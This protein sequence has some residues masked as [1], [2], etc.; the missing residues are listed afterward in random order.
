[1]FTSKHYINNI[2]LIAFA[3]INSLL[4]LIVSNELRFIAFLLLLGYLVVFPGLSLIS[5]DGILQ[6]K[7]IIPLLFFFLLIFFVVL[8]TSYKAA[9]ILPALAFIFYCIYLVKDSTNNLELIIRMFM[10]LSAPV[11]ILEIIF[12]GTYIPAVLLL[13][14]II[15]M[16]DKY[17]DTG[18]PAYTFYTL[19]LLTG[20]IL[21]VSSTLIIFYIF[22]IFYLF[23]DD[24][25]RLA[26]F[27]MISALTFIFTA[28]FISQGLVSA[29][30]YQYF[31]FSLLFTMPVWLLII[32]FLALIYIAWITAD[33]QE[34]HFVSALFI[35][36]PV[37]VMLVINLFGSG[38]AGLRSQ[39]YL[40]ELQMTVPL[41]ITAVRDYRIDKFAGKI[42]P[43]G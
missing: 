15:Y 39:N 31:N 33:M 14:V 5:R 37:V 29:Y 34:V 41:F 38:L 20:G 43:V 26:I 11:L 23:R 3:F 27:V 8:F 40:T 7:I 22:F 28:W 42:M 12:N 19:A 25:V 13:I 4:V 9:G 1:M 2:S 24:L 6:N 32:Y 18:K 10:F 36:V 16:L 30:L 17:S 35:A 21:V